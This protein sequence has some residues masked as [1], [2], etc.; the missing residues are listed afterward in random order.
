MAAP[1]SASAGHCAQVR[2]S[3]AKLPA[4]CCTRCRSLLDFTLHEE[5]RMLC[6][7]LVAVLSITAVRGPLLLVSEVC[8]YI[9]HTS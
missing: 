6:C 7:A 9:I 5:T 4:A 1:A 2:A 8:Q 3:S